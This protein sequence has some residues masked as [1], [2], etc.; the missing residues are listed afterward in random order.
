[1]VYNVTSKLIL[2]RH[3]IKGYEHADPFNSGLRNWGISPCLNN[4]YFL[5]NR[6]AL[7]WN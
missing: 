5:R 7:F 4:R 6:L 2:I 3:V 1:V